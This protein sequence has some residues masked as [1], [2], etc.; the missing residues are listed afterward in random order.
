MEQPVVRTPETILLVD[1]DWNVRRLLRPALE[2]SG[3][4]VLEAGS[5]EAALAVATDL[6]SPIDL[7]V[8]DSRMPGMSG[9][10][11]AVRFAHLRPKIRILFISGYAD[12]D[13]GAGEGPRAFLQ[14]PFS[15]DVLRERVRELLDRGD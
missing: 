10:D 15:M 12:E 1:D 2:K 13:I 9:L 7:L 6:A 5:A 14:K 11:L 8:T 3:Y 4:R